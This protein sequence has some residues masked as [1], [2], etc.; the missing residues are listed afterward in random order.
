LAAFDEDCESAEE[1]ESGDFDKVPDG[2]YQV[3]VDVCQLT[4]TKQTEEPML[5]MELRIIGPSHPG[6]V[7]FKNYLFRPQSISFFKTDMSTMGFKGIKPSD[8][9]E[10]EVLRKF[11]GLKLNIRIKTNGEYQN[12]YINS[13]INEGTVS[14]APGA[15]TTGQQPEQKAGQ[16]AARK[17]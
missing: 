15:N 6:R 2:S 1:L 14:G 7:V 13:R 17:W 10:E 9:S 4:R 11:L 12:I 8:L 5:K 3:E 16:R